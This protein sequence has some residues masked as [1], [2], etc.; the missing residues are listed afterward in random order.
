MRADIRRELRVSAKVAKERSARVSK[1]HSTRVENERSAMVEKGH[2]TTK[3]D[4]GAR[5]SQWS[6]VSQRTASY[7]FRSRS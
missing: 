3:D 2:S 7:E 6:N 1:E 5:Y 4:K